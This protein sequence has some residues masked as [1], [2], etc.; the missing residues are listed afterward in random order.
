MYSADDILVVS[1][2]GFAVLAAVD[3]V[4]IQV[5]VVCETHG[6]LNVLVDPAD[7]IRWLCPGTAGYSW[8][9]GTTGGFA[10]VDENVRESTPG[11]LRVE[12]KV[13]KYCFCYHYAAVDRQREGLLKCYCSSA[14]D[15]E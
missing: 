12:A 7:S 6:C 2:V 13:G 9:L 14:D 15:R 5:R 11:G 8:T 4:T 3:P 1:K 10:R